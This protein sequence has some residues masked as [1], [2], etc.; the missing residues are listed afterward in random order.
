MK[1]IRINCRENLFQI[2]NLL[3]H[4][5]DE[6]YQHPSAMLSG[7]SIGAHVRHVLEF[8]SCLLSSKGIV[9]YD[10]RQRNQQVENSTQAAIGLINQV[11]DIL[12]LTHED[13][14]I[15]LEGVYSPNSDD[16]LQ[17]KTSLNRE[18]VYCLEHSIHHQALIKISLIELGELELIDQ[19]FGIA[20]ATLRFRNFVE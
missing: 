10:K 17:L 2:K 20:P 14:A 12:A 5:D 9:N 15:I 6:A 18:L 8:Y 1:M 11:V 7:A 19:S 13:Y 3:Q 4:L 16:V